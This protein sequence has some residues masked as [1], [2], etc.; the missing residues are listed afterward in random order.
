MVVAVE[1]LVVQVGRIFLRMVVHTVH[2]VSVGLVVAVF[3]ACF[4]HRGVHVPLHA[5][6]LREL[7]CELF[8]LGLFEN[9]AGVCEEVLVFLPVVFFHDVL[10]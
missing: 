2:V 4:S 3:V 1:T 7:L 6:A 9:A 10:G 5:E 8:G